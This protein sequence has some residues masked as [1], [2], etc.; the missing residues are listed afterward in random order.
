MPDMR[1]RDADI[2]VP[3]FKSKVT[4]VT[5]TIVQLTRLHQKVAR[6]AIVGRCPAHDLPVLTITQLLKSWRR[7]RIWHARRNG[8][9]IAGLFLKRLFG[10]NIAVVFTCSNPRPRTGLTRAMLRHVDAIVGTST[11][12]QDSM[13]QP[14]TAI[15]PH[16]IDRTVFRPAGDRA[17]VRRQLGLPGGFLIGSFG[18][19]R[20]E[21]GTDVLVD[22]GLGLLREGRDVRFLVVGKVARGHRSYFQGLQHRIAAAGMR[23]RFLFREAVP[24][25]TIP[26][27]YQALDLFVAVPRWEGFGLTVL[28]AI[29]SGVPVVASRQGVFASIVAPGR[30]GHLVACDRPGDVR[31]AIA[32][33]VGDLTGT[34]GAY[35][36]VMRHIPDAYHIETEARRLLDLYEDLL[37]RQLSRNRV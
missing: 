6:V 16:G 36:D 18:R 15:V 5:A 10:M 28:E 3:N 34:R 14:L 4:G 35:R 7:P 21:K 20:P 17:A 11:A 1:A 8:E 19:I 12:M 32:M 9:L 22:A 33:M 23:E 27:W 37:G 2:L 24:Y 31:E 29:A 25:E 13:P 30:T 26:L